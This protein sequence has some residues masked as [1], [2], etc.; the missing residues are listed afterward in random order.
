MRL[1]AACVPGT[2]RTAKV[3]GLIRQMLQ[4][5]WCRTGFHLWKVTASEARLL[6]KQQLCSEKFC[7]WVTDLLEIIDALHYKAFQLRHSLGEEKD[8]APSSGSALLPTSPA[9][10]TRPPAFLMQPWQKK[11]SKIKLPPEPLNRFTTDPFNFQEKKIPF[12][13]LFLQLPL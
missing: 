7:H 3:S 8:C 5:E 1:F 10:G 9:E 2:I 11:K 4:R 12:S 13:R 6:P